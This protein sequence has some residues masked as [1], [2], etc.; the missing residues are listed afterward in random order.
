MDFDADDEDALWRRAERAWSAKLAAEN[1]AVVNLA[2]ANG[3]AGGGGAPLI[4]VAEGFVRSPDLMATRG[5]QSVYWEVKYRTRPIAN[6]LTGV[7]EHWMDRAK[8]YDYSRV[9]RGTGCV[10]NVVLY[11]A[12]ARGGNGQWFMISVQDLV[13]VGRQELRPAADLTDV[14]AWVW[15][16]SAMTPV[17]GPN[18]DV[19]QVQRPVLPDEGPGAPIPV[20]VLAPFERNLRR[21]K[22]QPKEKGGKAAETQSAMEEE[23]VKVIDDDHL[24]GLQTR[25]AEILGLPVCPRYSVLYVGADPAMTDELLRLLDY[26][27]RLFLVTPTDKCTFDKSELQ[28][29]LDSRL[30]EWAV[31]PA[32]KGMSVAVVDGAGY[33]SLDKRTVAVLEAADESGGINLLQY[34]VVHAGQTRNVVVSAGAGT[35]KTETMS[36]RIIFLLA[37]VEI[38]DDE[39]G[40]VSGESLS[41]SDIVLVTFTREAARQMRE[42][43]A[44]SLNLRK[45]LS[46]LCVLPAVAWMMELSSTEISTIHSYAKSI[47]QQGAGALGLSPGFRVAKQTM[48]FREELFR[49]LSPHLEK[50]FG[51]WPDGEVPASHEWRDL[52]QTIWDKLDNNGI[53][54]MPLGKGRKANIDWPAAKTGT[55]EAD[56]AQAVVQVIDQVGREFAAVCLENQAIPT[57]KLVTTALAVLRQKGPVPV[58]RPRY[59]FVDEFQDTDEEQMNVLVQLR[60]RLGARLFVVGDVKQAIYRFRGA[61]S[62]AFDGLA[63]KLGAIGP[64]EKPVVYRLTRNFRSGAKLLD[65]LNPYF[66]SWGKAGILPYRAQEDRLRVNPLRVEK[67]RA[68]KVKSV[69]DDD[70]AEE[71]VRQVRRWRDSIKKGENKKI[72]VL[73]RHNWVAME[74]QKNLVAN[75]IQCELMVGGDFFR[76]PAVRELRVLLEA[77]ADP[78]DNAALLE[79]CETRWA[80]RLMSQGAPDGTTKADLSAWAEPV[81]DILPWRDRFAR[82]QSGS[83][84]TADLEPLRARVL[85]LRNLLDKMPV[86]SWVI[87]CWQHFMPESSVMPGINEPVEQARYVRCLE[88]LLMLMDAEFGESPTTIHRMLEWLRLQIA[89]NRNEDEPFAD[90][91]QRG[92]VTALTVHKSKGLEFDMV[93]IPH[94]WAPFW[95]RHRKVN[96]VITSTKSGLPRIAWEWRP[97]FMKPPQKLPTVVS[98]VSDKDKAWDE[99]KDAVREE[100]ARLMYVAMTRAMDDLVVFVKTSSPKTPRAHG[101]SSTWSDLVRKVAGL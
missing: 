61:E 80:T 94:T 48:Q 26:G 40:L 11:D 24:V 73:C 70:Y 88:H 95:K 84:E 63:Q 1:W 79:L 32:S 49:A 81:R 60:H 41:L 30:L 65:S 39:S 42:R 2:A 54:I 67:G 101:E 45:R 33:G 96:I 29:F 78:H 47:A 43:L 72:A 25:S 76:S 71:T 12:S 69:G 52:V 59:V 57:S 92:V 75:D 3:G 66:D 19:P 93:L 7:K 87:E 31:V 97:T 8:V 38:E 23:V 6:M 37:T 62:D 9:Q 35:G 99:E 27:I 56:A 53:E 10:V 74:L 55:F 16:L 98:N 18:L 58:R 4:E 64:G 21:R 36:E 34:E 50:I 51:K 14:D 13:A 68:V 85:S 82:I 77:V 89:T 91:D 15:P 17:A 44:K 90:D 28:A 86:L 83:L 22:N 20:G 100:E 46:R 5:G